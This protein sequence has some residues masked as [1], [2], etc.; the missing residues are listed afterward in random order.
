MNIY[1]KIKNLYFQIQ[2]HL[3]AKTQLLDR[4]NIGSLQIYPNQI[5][6]QQAML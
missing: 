2:T 4:G 1:N 6:F 3:V 5:I